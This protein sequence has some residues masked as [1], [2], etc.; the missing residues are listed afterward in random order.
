M[1]LGT[2]INPQGVGVVDH[3]SENGPLVGACSNRHEAR[4]DTDDIRLNVVDRRAGRGEIGLDNRVVLE[5]CQ[6]AYRG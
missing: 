3:H 2:T 6:K 5:E 4:L 1:S